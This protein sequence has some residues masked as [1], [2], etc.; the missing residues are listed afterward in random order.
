MHKYD[1]SVQPYLLK[2]SIKTKII[3]IIWLTR[4]VDEVNLE[5]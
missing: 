4:P 5:F 2:G 3:F 1:W